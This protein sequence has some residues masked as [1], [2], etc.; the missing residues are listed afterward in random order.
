MAG[1]VDYHSSNFSDRSRGHF[2]KK[3]KFRFLFENIEDGV[4]FIN[5]SYMIEEAN[6]RVLAML[7]RKRG[8][9]IGK[10]YKTLFKE[11]VQ[12]SG[13]RVGLEYCLDQSDIGSYIIRK[14]SKN[15]GTKVSFFNVLHKPFRIGKRSIG[16]FVIF[17]LITDK[18]FNDRNE[19]K[20][21]TDFYLNILNNDMTKNIHN[22]ITVNEMQLS[23]LDYLEEQVSTIDSNQFKMGL[24]DE[25]LSSD[26][27]LLVN[28][29]IIEECRKYMKIS[30]NQALTLNYLIS[31]IKE[32]SKLFRNKKKIKK[33]D[34]NKI[35]D[36]SLSRIKNIFYLKRIFKNQSG[37]SSR[38][39]IKGNELLQIAFDSIFTNVVEKNENEDILIDV[40]IRRSECGTY[41]EF[42]ISDNTEV[43]PE[44]DNHESNDT[45]YSSER[46]FGVSSLSLTLVHE[47]VKHSGGQL[48]MNTH[49][50]DS[51]RPG[52]NFVL[53]LPRG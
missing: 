23:K 1:K 18:K 6:S 45:S 8:D 48:V 15:N 38:I 39:T 46:F 36:Q 17:K 41:W 50:S 3:N 25:I 10:S 44:T 9:I 35:I 16:S 19:K 26:E 32:L 42:E 27:Y 5:D 49:D 47:I 51:N 31:N 13:D 11:L 52:N 12:Y 34:A 33:L 28:R 2:S 29:E 24:S 7:D 37:S 14:K 21:I 43:L 40:K 30:L 20:N 22:I 4:I 53:L